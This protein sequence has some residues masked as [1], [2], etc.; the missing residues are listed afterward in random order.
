MTGLSNISRVLEKSDNSESITINKVDLKNLISSYNGKL[1]QINNLKNSAISKEFLGEYQV[2]CS[3]C[4]KQNN[5][6]SESK[7]EKLDLDKVPDLESELAL[8]KSNKELAISVG[9]LKN[10]IF[11]YKILVGKLILLIIFLSCA[12]IEIKFIDFKSIELFNLNS[13]RIKLFFET[14]FK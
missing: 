1:T 11:S 9:N 5:N 14:V 8:E 4:E 6:K 2:S 3:E 12:N 10:Q 7:S 13:E